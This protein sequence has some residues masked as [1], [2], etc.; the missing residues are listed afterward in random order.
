MKIM[1]II[2]ENS[3]WNNLG[4]GF[5]QF[6][7]FNLLEEI[8][9]N[10]D[11]F[12]GEGPVKRAFHPKD[13]HLKN[14]LKLNEYQEADLHVFSGPIVMAL[15]ND[16]Y[17]IPIKNIV[18]SGKKYAL[19]SVSCSGLEGED[20]EKIRRFLKKY[21]PAIFSSRDPETFHKFKDYVPSAYNGIC[22][23][24]LVNNYLKIDT[25]KLEKKYFI[26]SF[27]KKPEPVYYTKS[28]S[29]K[30]ED[31]EMKERKNLINFLPFKIS[32]HL[33]I[34]NKAQESVGDLKVVRTVQQV[35][36]K[37]NNF[38]F[39]YPNSFITFNPINL[40][41]VFKGT[42]FTISER[43]HA[44]ATTLAFGKPAQIIID[45][46]RCGIFERLGF[47][48]R[49]NNGIMKPD[50]KFLEKIIIETKLLKEYIKE[51]I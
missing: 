41:A 23:A 4:D 44:C 29:P 14:A 48:W 50:K 42:E 46:P 36:N 21:P 6:S 27:Y 45:N 28:S 31:I 15:S 10:D 40:L 37:S 12:F 5:Y 16:E 34:Y 24:F 33:Q 38:N 43:V 20:L 13:K 11:I 7:L 47:D 3:T 2:V 1:K 51:N 30:I 17:K 32:R 18:E 9:P 26:S 39:K 25:L 49:S 8:F 22:T 35:S 19:I